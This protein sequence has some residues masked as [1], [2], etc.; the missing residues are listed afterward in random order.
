MRGAIL[1]GVSAIDVTLAHG[2]EDCWWH[3]DQ[4]IEFCIGEEAESLMKHSGTAGFNP[5]KLWTMIESALLGDDRVQTLIHFSWRKDPSVDDEL[6][7]PM[8]NS[9]TG[10][11]KAREALKD[12]LV[13]CRSRAAPI[14]ILVQQM[15]E[16]ADTERAEQPNGLK[17]QSG[18]EATEADANLPTYADTDRE[19]SSSF[20]RTS[21]YDRGHQASRQS[22]N[23]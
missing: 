21:G 15:V 18:E 10:Q 14:G 2:F 5:R 11:L 16:T 23:G 3:D 9:W 22:S 8:R 1:A 4:P 12:A 7:T 6:Q 19:I 17:K 13:G 20:S